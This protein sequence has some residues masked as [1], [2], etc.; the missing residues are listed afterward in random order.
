MSDLDLQQEIEQLKQSRFY[1][2]LAALPFNPFEVMD[3][4]KNE[5][6]HSKVLEWLLNDYEFSRRL[7]A[8]IASKLGKPEWK[9][10][11]FSKPEVSREYADPEAGRIDVLAHFQSITS[12]LVVGIEVKLMRLR[13]RNKYQTI[14]ISFLRIMLT[15]KKK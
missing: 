15:P 7:L 4:S 11:N 14:R 10:I 13:G 8:W 2:E 3:V 9:N 6:L 1:K 12:N 5:I